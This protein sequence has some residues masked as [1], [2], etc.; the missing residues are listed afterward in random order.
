MKTRLAST[1]VL[2]GVLLAIPAVALAQFGLPKAPAKKFDTGKVKDLLGKMDKVVVEYEDGTEK[3]W[4]STETTQTLVDQYAEGDF[5]LLNKNWSTLRK[6]LKDAKD[7][8]EK[9]SVIKLTDEYFKEMAER[10]KA[11]EAALA[12]PVKAADISGKLQV[13]EVETLKKIADEMKGV[14]DKDAALLKQCTT[15]TEEGLKMSEDLLAQAAKD[16]L[17]AKDYKDLAEKLK[18]GVDKLKSIAGELDKQITSVNGL[19]GHIQKLLT[20]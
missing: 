11:L 14:P 3:V 18:G 15:L 5:P 10:E 2:L 6:M 9:A 17:G 16:P 20:K 19:V 4:N 1:V 12:D 7:D 13:P 8:A